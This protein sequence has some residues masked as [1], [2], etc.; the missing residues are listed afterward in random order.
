M[1]V[2]LD[3]EGETR[4]MNAADAVD[5][6]FSTENFLSM[7]ETNTFNPINVVVSSVSSGG[8]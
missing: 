7:V 3:E 1:Q 5:W 8:G 2:S 6:L 4:A